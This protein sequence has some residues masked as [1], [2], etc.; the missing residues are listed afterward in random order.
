[1]C[2]VFREIENRDATLVLSQVISPRITREERYTTFLHDICSELYTLHYCQDGGLI[3]SHFMS[4]DNQA[5]IVPEKIRLSNV[6][7]TIAREPSD[8]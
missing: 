8:P 4:D 6:M 2:V 5:N 7:M 3:S 1:M